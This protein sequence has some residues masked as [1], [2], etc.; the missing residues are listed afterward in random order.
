MVSFRLDDQPKILKALHTALVIV[1]Y[2]R[3]FIVCLGLKV[4]E[5]FR[6]GVEP[7]LRLLNTA[8]QVRK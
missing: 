3:S 5:D 2:E 4:V 8:S 7:V 6:D 1:K